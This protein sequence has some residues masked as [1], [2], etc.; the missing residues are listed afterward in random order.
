[1]QV[2]LTEFAE[3]SLKLI[4]FFYQNEATEK[5]AQRVVDK[6]L[7]KISLLEYYPE[8]GKEE[9]LLKSLNQ[10]HRFILEGDFKIIYFM[11][12]DIVYITDIFNTKQN[13]AKIERHH[14]KRKPKT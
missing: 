9:D 1:M 7:S 11:K 5:V 14:R 4:F 13:P 6:I 2:I 8:R 12:S 10:N 3:Q